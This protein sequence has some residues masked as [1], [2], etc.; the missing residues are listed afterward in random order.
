MESFKRKYIVEILVI[1]LMFTGCTSDELPAVTNEASEVIAT[2][3]TESETVIET[4]VQE[5]ESSVVEEPVETLPPRTQEM[6][7]A[8]WDERLNYNGS[9][10]DSIPSIEGQWYIPDRCIASISIEDDD[11][12][13]LSDSLYE[14]QQNIIDN[15][16]QSVNIKLFYDI[17]RCDNRVLSVRYSIWCPTD[18]S[19]NRNINHTYDYSGK[20]LLFT[21]IVIDYPTFIQTVTPLIND[22]LPEEENDN[23]REII[24]GL[25]HSNP[26]DIDFYLT[27]RTFDF[28]CRYYEAE[29]DVSRS[30]IIHVNYRTYADLFYPEY[31]PGDGVLFSI[32]NRVPVFINKMRHDDVYDS[33]G[34]SQPLL[35]SNYNDRNYLIVFYSSSYVSQ[36][37]SVGNYNTGIPGFLI[38][39]YDAD[40][41][42]EIGSQEAEGLAGFSTGALSLDTILNF[43]AEH[44]SVELE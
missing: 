9:G 38:V 6:I 5:T 31:L 18:N 14:M 42:E 35:I 28:I 4:S 32:M 21:D 23:G 17:T 24:D 26:D 7:D 11:Y 15:L 34:S 10:I 30:V 13:C 33:T 36:E 19:Y 25:I 40:T 20:E 16:D 27:D 37:G 22:A 44:S 29:N 12:Q 1:S 8:A 43:V 3:G 39:L 2:T 41:G